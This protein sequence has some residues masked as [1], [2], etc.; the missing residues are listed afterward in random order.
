MTSAEGI[1]PDSIA[2]QAA[3]IRSVADKIE[4][5]AD[6]IIAISKMICEHLEKGGK[7]ITC[8]N[9]GS[10]LEA[11][12]LAAELISHFR[13]DRRALPGISLPLD[14]G[15]L[16]SI[17]NDFSFEEVFSR[18]VEA[19]ANPGD[20]VVGF[21]TSG[22]SANVAAALRTARAKGATTLAFTGKNPGK[23]GE[24]AD[25]LLTVDS[26]NTGRIQEGH[27]ILVHVICEDLD[28]RL[29]T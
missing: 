1:A 2:S 14:Y 18:Q 21:S 7:L 16:T 17:G 11:Q 28:A 5:A 22:N 10:A 3:E 27:L 29:A 25:Y 15:V 9:G 13:R 4:Q 19:L 20:V 12:H 24:S 8:G 23:V 6:E 26:T